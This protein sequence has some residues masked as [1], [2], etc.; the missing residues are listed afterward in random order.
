MLWEQSSYS[1][2]PGKFLYDMAVIKSPNDT[3]QVSKQYAPTV[4]TMDRQVTTTNNKCLL[5]DSF[6]RSYHS[7]YF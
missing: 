1:H 6:T 2:Q 5:F 3:G 4:V 7:S